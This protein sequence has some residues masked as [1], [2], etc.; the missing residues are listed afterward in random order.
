MA[1]RPSRNTAATNNLPDT[2]NVILGLSNLIREQ[3]QNHHDQIQQ[4]LQSRQTPPTPQPNPQSLYERFLRMKPSEF[5]GD[6]DPVVAEE[7]IKSLEVIFDYMQMDDRERVHCALFLLR[8]EA[9]NWWEGAK[10]GFELENLS[11]EAFK[12]Q[13]FEK[14]FSKDVRANKLKEFLELRQGNLTM[15]EYVRLFERG[16]LYAPFIAKDAEEKKNHFTRGLQPEIRR[17][18]R[19]SEA[20]TFRQMVDKALTAAQDESE[21]QQGKRPQPPTPRPWKKANFGNHKFKGKKVQDSSPKPVASTTKPTCSNCG[22]AHFGICVRDTELC[23]R[24]K[25]PGHKARDCPNAQ[26]RVPGRTFAMTREQARQDPTMIAGTV[27][28]LGRPVYALIDSGST[29]SFISSDA[30]VRLGLLPTQVSHEY[31]I[32]MP[33]GEEMITNRV[34]KNCPIQIKSQ[35]MRFDLI[36]LTIENFDLI[37]GMDWFKLMKTK[38]QNGTF[39]F[40]GHISVPD[41]LYD[42]RKSWIW[43]E[44]FRMQILLH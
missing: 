14:Y 41:V 23:F 11:W 15:T 43:K 6:P 10:E 29:H 20:T 1:G 5:H 26:T 40:G 21:I 2:A 34:V 19:M 39:V 38:K 44:I 7:W 36:V 4:L 37:M 13:F 32:S 22:K 33:S 42:K 31:R 3:A 27:L 18:I 17:D 24:C 28:I 16:C 25:K 35:P 9:R 8:N 30:C 12:V